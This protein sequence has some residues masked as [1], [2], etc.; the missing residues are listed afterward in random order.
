MRERKNM[1]IMAAL[2]KPPPESLGEGGAAQGKRIWKLRGFSVTVV[3]SF[4]A[5][6]LLHYGRTLYG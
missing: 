6:G 3:E 2:K 4:T 5:R 1:G